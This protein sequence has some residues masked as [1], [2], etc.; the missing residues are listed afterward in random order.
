[1]DK[2]FLSSLLGEGI[3]GLKIAAEKGISPDYLNGDV[4]AAYTYVIEH[5][6]QYGFMPTADMLF[7]KLGIALEDPDGKFLFWADE[8][9]NRRLYQKMNVGLKDVTDKLEGDGDPRTAFELMETL[10]RKLRDENLG[11]SRVRSVGS[12]LDE[13]VDFYRRVKAGETGILTPWATIN[14]AT[15]G[16]WPQ[17]LVLIA[18]RLGVGKTWF[19]LILAWHAWHVLGKKVL[20]GT[21]EVAQVSV[22][23]RFIALHNKLSYKELRHGKLSVFAEEKM[24]QSLEDLKAV[25]GFW[26]VGG[27]FDFRPETFDAAIEEVNPDLVILDGAYLLKMEG[28]NRTEQAANAFNELK[29]IAKRRKVAMVAST[30]FNRE[31]KQNSMSSVKVESIGLTDVAGWN[32]DQAFA[33]IQTDDMRADKRVMI[34]PLKLREG[35]CDS[36][37]VRWDLDAM[38]FRE[39]PKD[40]GGSDADEFGSGVDDLGAPPAASPDFPF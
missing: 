9:A 29:R 14:D 18:A 10:L 8:V 24:M 4:K 3:P 5:M 32:A 33:L 7:G 36:V 38:D 15:L 20:F 1:M 25:E 34:K 30:Q 27:D 22:G 13:A 19:V 6:S 11:S 16:F 37:E 23:L 21:T 40:G 2:G 17:D 35:T 28:S 26:I 12:A 39:L 31:V